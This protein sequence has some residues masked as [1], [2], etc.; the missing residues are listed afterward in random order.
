MEVVRVEGHVAHVMPFAALRSCTGSVVASASDAIDLA[1]LLVAWTQ[2]DGDAGLVSTFKSRGA[3]SSWVTSMPPPLP[4]WAAAPC[5]VTD[6]EDV[7]VLEENI[8]VFPVFALLRQSGGQLAAESN[9]SLIPRLINTI[10]ALNGEVVVV[11]MLSSISSAEEWLLNPRLPRWLLAPSPTAFSLSAP[12]ADDDVVVTATTVNAVINLTDS[13]QADDIEAAARAAFRRAA[14]ALPPPPPL[15][16]S[17]L[18]LASIKEFDA[19]ACR[20]PARGRD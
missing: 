10:K 5:S 3:A 4:T 11:R 12:G 1:R 9:S 17:I 8:P 6:D 7:I 2:L 19:S 14:L 18:S 13:E 16:R 20:C 15:K